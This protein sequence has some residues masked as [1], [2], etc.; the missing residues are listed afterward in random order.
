[1]RYARILAELYGKPWAVPQ[2]LLLRMEELLRQQAAG[3]KWS[4]DEVARRIATANAQGGHEAREQLGF[5]YYEIGAP[6]AIALAPNRSDGDYPRSAGMVAVLPITG[7]IAHRMNLV[8]DISGGG[9]TSIQKLQ[10]QFQQA[11][12]AENVRAI[13][14]DVDSPGGSVSGVPELA[15]QIYQSRKTKPIIAVVNTLAASAAYWLASAAREV[16]CMPSGQ[17]G[18]VGVF[19]LHED[20]SQALDKAG[21]KVSII[22]AGKY[23]TEGNSAEPLSQEARDNFQADVDEVY[24]VFVNAVAKNRGTTQ[25]KVRA[26]YGQGR[27]LLAPQAKEAGL[28]DRIGTFDSVLAKLGVGGMM[29]SRNSFGANRNFPAS[30]RQ[31]EL[32][33]LGIGTATP[34]VP[35]RINKPEVDK[36]AHESPEQAESPEPKPEYLK[37]LERRRRELEMIGGE[38]F[39]AQPENY[40]AGLKRRRREMLLN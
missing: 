10:A 32:D 19:I 35:G 25:A 22:K 3:V 37:A 34:F 15:E 29:P 14:L 5:R 38:S 23:K 30:R 33:M 1:M 2:D 24:S 9:G 36:Q 16:V 8:E 17:A 7:V 28:V 40:M 12:L 26:G 39:I 21:V 31:R 20:L 11:V 18:S 4:D 6:A 13:V 27:T